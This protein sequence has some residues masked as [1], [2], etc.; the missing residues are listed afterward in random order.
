MEFRPWRTAVC[1]YRAGIE[2]LSKQEHFL[3]KD[4]NASDSWGW[5][6]L[7][8]LVQHGCW[9][10]VQKASTIASFF[11]RVRLLPL[12]NS[13]RDQITHLLIQVSITNAEFSRLPT[14]SLRMYG[15]PD[16]SSSIYVSFLHFS[17]AQSVNPKLWRLLK[18]PLPAELTRGVRTLWGSLWVSVK[19]FKRYIILNS[20]KYEGR[21]PTGKMWTKSG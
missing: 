3:V 10:C 16:P 11:L 20:W 17:S 5:Q 9:Q 6:G 19:K 13:Y 2:V 15:P 4:P 12:E 8:P 14:Q 7:L 18:M 1:M 21:Q